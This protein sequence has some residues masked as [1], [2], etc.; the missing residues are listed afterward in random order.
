MGQ[1]DSPFYKCWVCTYADITHACLSDWCL[2]HCQGPVLM[3]ALGATI[4][5]ILAADCDWLVPKLVVPV[6]LQ[7]K[8]NGVYRQ[9]GGD[10][11]RKYN[12][13]CI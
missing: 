11:A 8:K 13:I 5:T 4:C 9:R 7:I 2:A 10:V 3:S 6:E 1:V 12:D